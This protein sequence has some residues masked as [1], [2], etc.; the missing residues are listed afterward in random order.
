MRTFTD[1]FILAAITLIIA[2]GC[3]TPL[4][5][6]VQ[7]ISTASENDLK[8]MEND[9]IEIIYNFWG[10]NGDLY[11]G[12]YNKTDKDIQILMDKSFFIRNGVVFDYYQ[13]RV[14]TVTYGTVLSNNTTSTGYT[15]YNQGVGASISTT[16]TSALSG[17]VKSNTASVTAGLS[18]GAIAGTAFSKSVSQSKHQSI[19]TREPI[20]ITI[21][22]KTTKTFNYFQISDVPYRSCDLLRYQF[23]HKIGSDKIVFTAENTPTFFENRIAYQVEGSNEIKRMINSFF[24]SEIINMKESKFIDWEM[25]KSGCPNEQTTSVRK[26]VLKPEYGKSNQFY[27]PYTIETA[28]GQYDPSKH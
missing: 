26:R 19:E 9:E 10:E 4:Y 8:Q 16:N 7:T 11:F 22:A 6:Q 17:T 2:A 3:S 12:I 23:D 25:V 18:M 15:N 28:K 14:Y 1:L 5:Y 13:D 24:I 20:S 27:I 21:P